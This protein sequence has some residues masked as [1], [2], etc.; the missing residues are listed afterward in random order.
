MAVLSCSTVEKVFFPTKNLSAVNLDMSLHA[1]CQEGR[2]KSTHQQEPPHLVHANAELSHHLIHVRVQTR[3][4]G[5]A[6]C[7]ASAERSRD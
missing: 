1:A 4:V 2:E 5:G 3:H 7:A 6:L